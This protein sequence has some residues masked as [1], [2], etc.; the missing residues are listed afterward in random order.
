[1]GSTFDGFC[2]EPEPNPRW[3][4]HLRRFQ[5]FGWPSMFALVLPCALKAVIS[6]PKSTSRDLVTNYR[7]A[8]DG[9]CARLW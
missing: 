9:G 5:P 1:M 8:C 7:T 2:L 3:L 6:I 4:T